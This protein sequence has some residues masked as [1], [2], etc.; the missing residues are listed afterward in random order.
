[1]QNNFQT[2]RLNRRQKLGCWWIYLL[3]AVL[4]AN[5]FF[6]SLPHNFLY[7]SA[8]PPL[9]IRA[10]NNQKAILIKN[11]TLLKRTWIWWNSSLH[12]LD[13]IYK[14]SVGRRTHTLSGVFHRTIHLVLQC[15]SICVYYSKNYAATLYYKL[16]N[17]TLCLPLRKARTH[18][19]RTCS[20]SKLYYFMSKYEREQLGTLLAY[21]LSLVMLQ[22]TACVTITYPVSMVSLTSR[23]TTVS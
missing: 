5:T 22:S 18:S 17:S 15:R 14:S 6:Y 1:M 21:Y 8:S 7:I 10:C 4:S 9:L 23:K 13:N 16:C 2:N 11:T 20:S 12:H 19:T 3:E